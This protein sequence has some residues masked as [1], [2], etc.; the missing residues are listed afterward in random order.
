MRSPALTRTACTLQYV[1]EVGT[2]PKSSKTDALDALAFFRDIGVTVTRKNLED[3]LH[4]SR[5]TSY[6]LIGSAEFAEWIERGILKVEGTGNRGKPDAFS[7][8]GPWPTEV[9]K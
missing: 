6:T 1:A 5:S 9:S 7:F 2:G 3:G 4:V 8:V